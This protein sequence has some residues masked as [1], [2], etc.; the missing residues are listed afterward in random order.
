[1]RKNLKNNYMIEMKANSLYGLFN[2]DNISLFYKS[3]N[4]RIKNLYKENLEDKIYYNYLKIKYSLTLCEKDE[5]NELKLL[6][7]IINITLKNIK[8]EN[9]VLRDISCYILKDKKNKDNL[10]KIYD[11]LLEICAEHDSRDFYVEHAESKYELKN[12]GFNKIDAKK[13]NIIIDL[14]TISCK[15]KELTKN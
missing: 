2:I 4:K 11:L 8:L 14:N 6:L 7:E 15:I 9:E 13:P 3:V 1:M 10:L 12:F 5:K